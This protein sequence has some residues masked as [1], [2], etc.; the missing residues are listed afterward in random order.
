MRNK[1]GMSTFTTLIQYSTG[2][3]EVKLSL[4]SDNMILYTENLKIPPKKKKKNPTRP[5]RLI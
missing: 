2:K 3:K 4:F 1:T 5:D